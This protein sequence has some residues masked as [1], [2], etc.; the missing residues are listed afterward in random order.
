MCD[1]GISPYV[2][3]VLKARFYVHS[4]Y[5]GVKVTVLNASVDESH[6]CVHFH[7]RIAGFHQKMA[8]MFWKVTPFQFRKTAEAKSE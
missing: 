4:I 5:A 2:I 7:W 8:A 3:A 1:R 6:G